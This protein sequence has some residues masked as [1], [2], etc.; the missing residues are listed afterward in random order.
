M[1]EKRDA[2]TPKEVSLS[3]VNQC[4]GAGII[5]K[6]DLLKLC[7]KEGSDNGDN[8]QANKDSKMIVDYL[9]GVIVA[10]RQAFSIYL[11][12]RGIRNVCYEKTLRKCMMQGC[13]K[14]C[15]QGENTPYNYYVKA[16]DS[17]PVDASMICYR[18]G[19]EK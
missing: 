12:K 2:A 14:Y 15:T 5:T 16:E 11:K 19:R 7:G 17:K 6:E 10:N 9:N 18:T 3:F 13:F 4:L 8:L 1:S